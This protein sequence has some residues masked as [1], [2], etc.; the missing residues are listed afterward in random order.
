MRN[1]LLALTALLG[2]ALFMSAVWAGCSAFLKNNEAYDRGLATA[3]ADPTVQQALGA[4]VR[5]SWFINGVIESDG[6]LRRGSWITRVR[7]ASRSGT[8]TIGGL[9]RAG[10]W[11]VVS[12]T[13]TVGDAAYTYRKGAGFEQIDPGEVPGFDIL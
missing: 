4:P 3:L 8:L 12:L 13:L 10:R 2:V 7:G 6:A 9:K 1:V 5:E 11:G